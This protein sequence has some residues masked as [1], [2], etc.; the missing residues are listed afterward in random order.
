MQR[1]NNMNRRI[2]RNHRNKRPMARRLG[3]GLQSGTGVAHRDMVRQ[4][5][6]W[7]LY[8]SVP[9]SNTSGTFAYGLQNINISTGTAG[10]ANAVYSRLMSTAALTYE[11]YRVRRVQVFAQPGTG[12]TNDLRIKSSLFGRVDVN[13]QP[14]VT[15]IDNLNS[16]ICSES[17]VNR[18]FT[19]RSNVKILEYRPICYSS[20]STGASSRPI[21]T[22]QLQWYNIEERSSHIWR[23]ATVCPVIPENNIQP[24]TLSVTVWADVEIEFRTRRPD[25]AAFQLTSLQEELNAIEISDAE[26]QLDRDEEEGDAT[27][28]SDDEDT[29]E[30]PRKL[31]K[32]VE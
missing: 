27:N 15:N 28:F 18:T 32:L 5:K 7:M 3:R 13:S 29:Y 9:Y 12:Y 10:I 25:F 19:E 30:P 11:E 1:Q 21:L 31:A 24:N 8:T 2:N 23:G 26:Q 17:S 20:G 6:K 14:T 22:S 16:V 4:A